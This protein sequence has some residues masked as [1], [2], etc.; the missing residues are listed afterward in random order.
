MKK[1][2]QLGVQ[3]NFF[4]VPTEASRRKLQIAA[5]YFDSYMNVLARDRDAG[6]ADLFAGPGR[7]ENGE[8]SVPIAICERVVADERL[9]EFA[10]LWFNEADPELHLKLE[11]NIA[12]VEGISHLKHAPSVT[13]I[14]ISKAL[15]P[16]ME[17]LSIPTFVFA[18]PCGYKGLSL[19]LVTATLKGFGNDCLFFFNYNRVNMKL[20]YPVMDESIDEFFEHERAAVLREEI[21][22]LTPPARERRVLA[23]I[24]EAL[25]HAGAIPLTFAFR[26]REGGGTSH[27]LVFASK[28]RKG[29]GIMKRLMNQASSEIIDGVGSWDFDPRDGGKSL[30]LFSGLDEVRQRVLAAFAGRALTFEQVIAEEEPSTRF[31]ESNYRDALLELEGEGRILA[32]PPA[33]QRPLQAGGHKRTLSRRTLITFPK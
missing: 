21:G 12:A 30:P 29:V 4:A 18:D 14:L 31:T 26:T 13:R 20:G 2:T 17:W 5:G 33:K 9:R 16:R 3:Q 32:D 28:S 10:R 27:H 24:D 6:Y 25:R 15:A 7:Y 19:R 23:A 22:K 11:R 8:R 1:H